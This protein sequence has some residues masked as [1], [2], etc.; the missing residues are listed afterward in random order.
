MD[1]IFRVTYY[2]LQYINL[3]ARIL[4]GTHNVSQYLTNRISNNCII[5]KHI[6]AISTFV[7]LI[8]LDFEI[9]FGNLIYKKISPYIPKARLKCNVIV[10]L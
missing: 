3:R 10:S 7:N 9:I 5:L 2:A 6:L 8:A 4:Y 1:I